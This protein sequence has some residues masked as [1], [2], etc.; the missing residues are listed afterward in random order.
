MKPLSGLQV[1]A[2]AGIMIV[3]GLAAGALF[4]LEPWSNGKT[5]A[6]PS[7]TDSSLTLT[8]DAKGVAEAAAAAS[9]AVGFAVNPPDASALGLTVK[10]IRVDPNHVAPPGARVNPRRAVAFYYP[11][12]VD[13]REL[14]GGVVNGLGMQ[15]TFMQGFW[16]T[17]W[18]EGL[19][20]QELAFNVPGFQL[21]VAT[22]SHSAESSADYWVVS[23]GW[24]YTVR[25]GY[26]GAP[27]GTKRPSD[28]QML[29]FLRVLAASK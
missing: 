9:E 4:A 19:S 14:D 28:A 25:V 6:E 7:E 27:A 1:V 24:T 3:A 11:G 23:A 29:P 18:G 2:V 26:A 17:S 15:V 10:G 8:Y 12:S 20:I 22:S 21:F 13:P 5:H 16:E